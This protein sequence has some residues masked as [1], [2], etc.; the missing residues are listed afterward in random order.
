MLRTGAARV[1][2]ARRGSI[3]FPPNAGS[4]EGGERL[5]PT[6][7]RAKPRQPFAAHS[8]HSVTASEET[9]YV[10]QGM[11]ATTATQMLLTGETEEEKPASFRDELEAFSRASVEEHGL[12]N[13]SQAAIYLGVSAQRVH[14]LIECRKLTPF[15]FTGRVYVSYTELGEFAKIERPTGRPVTTG[16]RVVAGAKCAAHSLVDP[17][18]RSYD[19]TKDF[20]RPKKKA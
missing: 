4:C 11:S 19:V 15:R 12:I 1:L 7:H 13:L 5:A 6:V 16:E 14:Q 8:N 18:Q 20:K 10:L 2:G 9:L 3:K 17:M